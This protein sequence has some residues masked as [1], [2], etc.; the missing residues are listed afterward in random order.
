MPNKINDCEGLK[1]TAFP[2]TFDTI[3]PNH[4]GYDVTD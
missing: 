3:N 4:A 2:D 1:S